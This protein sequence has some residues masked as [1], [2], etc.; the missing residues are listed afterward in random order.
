MAAS[1]DEI[2][3]LADEFLENHSR[4]LLKV[5]ALEK[6]FWKDPKRGNEL[7]GAM[8]DLSQVMESAAE[9]GKPTQKAGQVIDKALKVIGNQASHMVPDTALPA[10]EQEYINTERDKLIRMQADI[11]SV[12]QAMGLGRGRG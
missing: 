1:S 9:Y 5:A 11:V 4:T 7:A 12:R 10:N 3:K 8:I 6:D 2:K